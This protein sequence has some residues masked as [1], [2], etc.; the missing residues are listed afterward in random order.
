MRR[1]GLFLFAARSAIRIERWTDDLHHQAAT[2]RAGCLRQEGRRGQGQGRRAY[3]KL[4][5]ESD[6]PRGPPKR[7]QVTAARAKAA[8]LL[9]TPG[10]VRLLDK[11]EVSAIAGVT[12]PSI[13]LWM[14]EGAFPRSRIVGGKSMWRSDEI[15]AW[16]AALPVRKLKGD[17]R[18]SVT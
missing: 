4:I 15:D 2:G 18:G 13:W 3:P 6:L 7:V 5:E 1:A 16:L 12:Y 17:A 8:A 10:T 9:A 14:R 11:H